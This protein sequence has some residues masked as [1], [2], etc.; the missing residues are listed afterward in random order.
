[1]RET[2]ASIQWCGYPRVTRLPRAPYVLEG[3]GAAHVESVFV[4]WCAIVALVAL[5]SVSLARPGTLLAVSGTLSLETPLHDSPDP[6]APVGALL[7]GG[8]IVS[9]DGPPVDGF[10]PVTAGSLS[11]RM[12]GETSQLEKDTPEPEVAED[13]QAD[14]LV[15]ATDETVSVKT[16]A[17]VDPAA[18]PDM[19]T[20]LDPAADPA[21]AT[22][23]AVEGS[24][25]DAEW[26]VPAGDVTY[27]DQNAMAVEPAA[28]AITATAG[29]AY[30][31]DL[32][33]LSDLAPVEESMPP[34]TAAVSHAP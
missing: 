20:E 3:G 14:L 19:S 11:G 28:G 8:G 17:A 23:P 27:D 2:V 10:Y 12:R 26:A 32:A 30:G 5:V 7:T 33:A 25:A 31:D 18:D 9:I 24:G 4:C 16:P 34:D 22:E 13:I 15:E 1:M 21:P 29:S 6:A